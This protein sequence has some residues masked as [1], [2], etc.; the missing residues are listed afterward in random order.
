MERV[1]VDLFGIGLRPT[2]VHG[3]FRD[4]T[5]K[6]FTKVEG[7]WFE[8][9]SSGYVRDGETERHIAS[10]GKIFRK[11][12]PDKR[13]AE[14]VARLEAYMLECFPETYP[15]TMRGLYPVYEKDGKSRR[16]LT[17]E[18]VQARRA[19]QQA[20]Y[21]NKKAAKRVKAEEEREN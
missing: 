3:V 21:Q 16:A 19:T 4:D 11:P 6:F 7:D 13:E 1:K 17:V 9:F 12:Q 15:F 2:D 14:R 18:E 8:C 10:Y 5:G 20:V